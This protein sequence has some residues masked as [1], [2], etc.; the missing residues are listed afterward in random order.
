MLFRS[1]EPIDRIY[2]AGPDAM[3]LED[4][5]R[6][7]DIRHRGFAD[8][9][10]WNPGCVLTATMADMQPDGFRRMLCVEAAAIEPP[11]SLRAGQSWSGGQALTLSSHP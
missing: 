6:A 7:F 11:V 3:R 9:V 1:A 4:A 10:V 5:A 8:T 2:F